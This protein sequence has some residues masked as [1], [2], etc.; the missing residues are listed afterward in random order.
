[1]VTAVRTLFLLRHAKSSWSDPALADQDRPLAPRGRRAAQRMARYLLA[2]G[3]R[4]ELVWC[5]SARRAR[6]TLDAVL[7]AIGEDAEVHVTDQVYDSG[8]DD[9]LELLRGIED[10]VTSVMIVGHNPA[11]QDL[12]VQ[13]SGAGDDAALSLL[14]TKF[15]TGALAMLDLGGGAWDELGPHQAYLARLVAPRRLT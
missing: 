4:P 15:P 1:M 2:S 3:V 8:A 5:S 6:D 10:R 7:P 12:A 13:L 14:H 9:L 11:L